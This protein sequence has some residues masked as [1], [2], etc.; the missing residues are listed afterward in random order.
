M[1]LKAFEGED[2]KHYFHLTAKNNEIILQS[3]AYETS[4]GAEIGMDSVR[5]NG[6]NRSN[7][8]V[9]SSEG[10]QPYF[11]LKAQ[12]GEVIG[13]SETYSSDH[14]LEGGIDSVIEN[15]SE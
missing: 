8:E 5:T 2:G 6:I 1:G 14:A 7:F 11:V 12:N 15:L 10:G 13:V 3:E 9:R 4:Q